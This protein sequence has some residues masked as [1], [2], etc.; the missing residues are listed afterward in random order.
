MFR[1]SFGFN[2]EGIN[3]VVGNSLVVETTVSSIDVDFAVVVAGSGI[4]SG[5]GCTD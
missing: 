1:P 3:V 4:S 5:G 2:V